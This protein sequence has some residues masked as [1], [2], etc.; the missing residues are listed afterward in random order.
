VEDFILLSTDA[1]RTPV[2]FRATGGKPKLTSP[3]AKDFLPDKWNEALSTSSA[4]KNDRDIHLCLA[5][6]FFGKNVSS[7]RQHYHADLFSTI[8]KRSLLVL[9]VGS[10]NRNFLALRKDFRKKIKSMSKDTEPYSLVELGKSSVENAPQDGMS[11]DDIVTAIIDTLPHWFFEAR[12]LSTDREPLTTNFFELEKR[13][14]MTLSVESGFGDLWNA[15]LWEGSRLK[16]ETGEMVFGPSNPASSYFWFACQMRADAALSGPLALYHDLPEEREDLRQLKG[17]VAL[18]RKG[19]GYQYSA[20]KPTKRSKRTLTDTIGILEKSY[21]SVFLDE[22]ISIAGSTITARLLV[23]ALWVLETLASSKEASLRVKYIRNYRDAKAFSFR[24]PRNACVRLIKD[25]LGLEQKV[26]EAIFAQLLLD[27]DDTKQCFNQGVWLH[28]IIEL[29]ADDVMIVYP[30]V[31]VGSKLRFVERTL[32]E[33][34]GADLKKSSSQGIEFERSVRAQVAENL[35]ANEIISD[36][37]VLH[38]GLKKNS[39]DGEEIDLLFR[40]GRTIILGE[41]KCLLAPTES[42]DRFNHLSKLEDA[43]SQANRKAIW[44][45]SNLNLV[46]EHLDITNGIDDIRIVPLVVLNQRI[47]SGLTIEGVAITDVFLLRLFVGD[48]SYNSGAAIGKGKKAVT[49]TEFYKTQAEAEAAVETVFSTPPPLQP[50][51]KA[52]DWDKFEYPTSSG[53]LWIEKP[54]LKPD[55]LVDPDMIAAAEMIS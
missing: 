33:L 34:L 2:F 18:C 25:C 36:F 31:A 19:G 21:I 20:Q 5:A 32:M 40:I 7:L 55:S 48:G 8:S 4:E 10:A 42:M 13:V 45:R 46:E 50:F 28:P 3:F 35:D 9:A 15:A 17:A 27:P 49:F 12:H 22:K 51:L 52:A 30:S 43:A 16:T 24:V 37:A 26:A 1:L 54:T 6:I 39:D 47:G 23:Q 38:H 41:I 29:D 14:G 44:L 11:S 53:N